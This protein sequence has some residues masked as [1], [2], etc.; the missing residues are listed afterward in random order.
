MGAQNGKDLLVKLDMTGGGTAGGGQF[1]TIA[2]LRATRISFNAETVDVTS[3]DSQGGWRE[4]LGGAGVRSAAVSGSGVF[5]DDA[6]DERVDDAQLQVSGAATH[7]AQESFLPVRPERMT[8]A[9]AITAQGV[10]G[11][12]Q[13][14]RRLRIGL[15]QAVRALATECGAA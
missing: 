3:L 2:G 10:A 15:R 11:H 12:H 6:S 5:L 1:Q 9:E 4:L 14:R 13:H 8:I 7:L